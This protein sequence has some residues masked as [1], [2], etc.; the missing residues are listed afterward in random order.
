MNIVDASIL[1][2]VLLCGVL[3]FKKGVIK[4]L[5]Q[6]IGTVAVVILAYTL[7]GVLA[8]F[9]MGFMPFFNFGGIFEGVTAMNI[10]MYEM[11]S[12]VVIFILFYCILNI[13]LSLSGLIETV[14]KF[15]VVLAIPSKILGAI[16]GLF[17]GLLIAFMLC[18]IMLHLPATEKYVI[19]SYSGVILLERTP[20]VGPVMAR[21]TLALESINDVVK[22]MQNEENR[23]IVNARVL[24]ELIHFQIVSGEDI[25]QLI[26]SKKIDLEGITITGG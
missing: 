3:G 25:N 4:S 6:L 9:L 19:D 14:L 23:T 5:V 16:V 18:F 8:N 21:T 12:F 7:K 2:I 17:E 13:L 22:D 26:D 24:Q 15:T 20:F 11:I 10:L 1:L